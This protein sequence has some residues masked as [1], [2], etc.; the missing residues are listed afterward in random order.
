[1]FT[2]LSVRATVLFIFY[3]LF[4]Y[5]K[6]DRGR[7]GEREEVKHRLASHMHPNQGPNHQIRPVT[8]RFAE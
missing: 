4:I 2:Q 8:P 6:R 5:F 1:M 7:E 3:I